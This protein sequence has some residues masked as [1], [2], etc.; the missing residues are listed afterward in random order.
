M[1]MSIAIVL[2]VVWMFLYLAVEPP[3]N[4]SCVLLGVAF[5]VLAF[6]RWMESRPR[7]DNKRRPRQ[8]PARRTF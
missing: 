6:G 4:V 8:N 3:T 5:S 7:I 1:F 2:M